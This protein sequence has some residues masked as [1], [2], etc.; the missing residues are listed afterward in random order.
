MIIYCTRQQTTER[1]AQLIRTSLQYTEIEEGVVASGKGKGAKKSHIQC[2]AD[3]YHAGL[4]PK[5]RKQIQNNFMKGK[6]RFV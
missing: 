2:Q 6:L 3:C 5:K 4:M 1:I